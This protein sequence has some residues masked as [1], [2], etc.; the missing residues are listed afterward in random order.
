MITFLLAIYY[1]VKFLEL[2]ETLFL[3]LTKKISK[4]LK[5]RLVDD[6]DYVLYRLK[7]S[8]C[9]S[10]RIKYDFSKLNKLLVDI[11]DRKFF[12]HNGV[13]FIALVRGFFILLY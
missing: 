1:R 13:D 3:L 7:L 8:S 5:I 4:V 10:E 6:F 11:E 2:H 12:S 9:E